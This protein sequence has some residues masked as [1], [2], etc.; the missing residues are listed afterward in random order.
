MADSMMP[1][2]KLG[3]VGVT[4][5]DGALYRA[6]VIVTGGQRVGDEFVY[7]CGLRMAT[8]ADPVDSARLEKLA[9]EEERNRRRH[10]PGKT[11][12]KSKAK[13]HG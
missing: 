11:V 10:K 1:G 12:K 7:T 4:G 6:D 9:V 3:T 2:S 5:E 13:S 8:D